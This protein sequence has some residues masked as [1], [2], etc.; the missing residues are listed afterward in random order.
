M[1]R[2]Y[3][4]KSRIRSI[5]PVDHNI[6]TY[7][8]HKIHAGNYANEEGMLLCMECKKGNVCKYG[9]MVN[10]SVECCSFM[11]CTSTVILAV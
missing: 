3:T 1:I 6:T 11:L 4:C 9:G 7:C 5:K 10:V 2:H 8:M